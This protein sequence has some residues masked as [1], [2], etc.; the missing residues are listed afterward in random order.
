[1]TETATAHFLD[2]TELAGAEITQEQ[3]E[4]MCHRYYWAGEYC[5]GR[6]VLEVA[7]GT[8]PGLRYLASKAHS[9]KA[10]DY[11]A[12]VLA[13]AKAHLGDAVDLRAFDAQEIPYPDGSFDVIMMFEALYYIP[14][15]E[16]FVAQARRLLRPGGVLLIVNAN[17]DLYDFNPSPFSIVYHGVTELRDL[18]RAGGF[19]PSFFG[20]L[21]TGAVSL[22][23]RLLRP[24]KGFAVRFNLMPK[25]MAGKLLLKR[26]VF[27]RMTRMPDSVAAGMVA[28]QPPEPIAADAVDHDHKVIYCAAK[29]S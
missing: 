29:R 6:D 10:G 24:L 2:V 5:A 1:M 16:R 25:T 7:C 3:L 26:L 4:R 14:S 12:E 20:Y 27:G 22:R 17:K 15:A 13:R 28:Y 21:R 11:S 9:L 19:E 23:Q 8:G 18:V